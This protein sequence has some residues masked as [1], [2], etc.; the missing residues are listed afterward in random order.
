MS[1]EI[2][3]YIKKRNCLVFIIHQ[4]DKHGVSRRCFTEAD[5]KYFKSGA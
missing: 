4:V 5:D 2:N 3:I 1:I